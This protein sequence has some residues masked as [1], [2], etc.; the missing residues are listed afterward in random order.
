MASIK[1]RRNGYAVVY[2]YTNEQNERKQRWEQFS[3]YPEAHKRR[4]EI[5]YQQDKGSF[6]APSNQTVSKFLDDFVELYG[7]RKWGVSVY[8]SSTSLIANYINP[9]IGDVNVQD[10]NPRAADKFVQCLQKTKPVEVMGRAAKTETLPPPT[11][12]KIIKLMSCAFKQAVR[13][14]LIGKNPFEGIVLPKVEKTP[15]D[16][17]TSD[18]IMK[19]L[20]ECKDAKCNW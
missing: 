13:W 8:R 1:K 14:E 2:Y 11:I 7:V 6:V 12:E 20:E 10:V 3:S 5:E 16:I 9:I 18:T 19:A 15:R 4:A 17:W